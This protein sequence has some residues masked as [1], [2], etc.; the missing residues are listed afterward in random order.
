M[1][2]PVTVYIDEAFQALY[3]RLDDQQFSTLESNIV[4]SGR[5]I[6]PIII[7]E[8]GAILDGHHRYRIAVKH[9]LEYRCTTERG[10][11]DREKRDLIFSVNVNQRPPLSNKQKREAVIASLKADP[12]LSDREHARRVGVSPNFVGQ[13]RPSLMSSEDINEPPERHTAS[14]K[15]APG[16]KPKDRAPAAPPTSEA[17]ADDTRDVAKPKRMMRRKSAAEVIER[18]RDA[19]NGMSFA[20]DDYGL[21]NLEDPEMDPET[22]QA[23]IDDIEKSLRKFRRVKAILQKV[24][25]T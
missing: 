3:P 9:G 17:P 22:A 19:V 13:I 15:R 11:S 14:G 8:S 18:F 4:A 24:I 7:D 2:A 10:L 20:I 23:I 1:A 5:I 6:A 16:P 25:S 12:G 21:E